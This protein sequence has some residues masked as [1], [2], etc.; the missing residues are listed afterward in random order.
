[1]QNNEY[2]DLERAVISVE[3]EDAFGF[4]QNMI[5]NDL[6]NAADHKAIYSFL[7]TPQGKYLF[8]FFI[9]KQDDKYLIEIALS[10]KDDFL[11]KLKMYKLRSKVTITDLSE[12]YEVIASSGGYADPRSAEMPH[13]AIVTKDEVS[14]IEKM[15]IEGYHWLRVEN[16]IPEG[17]YDLEKDKSYPLQYRMIELNGV[18]F[19]KGCYVGQE[20][21]ARTHHRGVIRKTVYKIKSEGGAPVSGQEITE[22]GNSVGKVLSAIGYHALALL[23]VEAVQNH[24]DKL[25]IMGSKVTILQ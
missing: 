20:V 22:N 4:L 1:M 14:A 10:D 6:A 24:S 21:T 17:I 12:K 8:D 3:G 19:K 7:L 18:D 13:R 25:E 15:D 11:K 16:N 2:I 5:S 9:S 23:E